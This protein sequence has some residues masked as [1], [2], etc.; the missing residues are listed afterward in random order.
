[1]ISKWR[2]CRI[3]LTTASSRPAGVRQIEGPHADPRV[4]QGEGQSG[5]SP[6]LLLC[7]H[8]QEGQHLSAHQGASEYM[9]TKRSLY[10]ITKDPEV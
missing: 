8:Q 9:V 3:F 2:R 6:H 5:W 1:M 10:L 7:T 4:Q